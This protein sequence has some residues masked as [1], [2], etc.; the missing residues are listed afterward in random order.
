MAESLLVVLPLFLLGA[1]A[2]PISIEARVK[3]RL[4]PF[5]GVAG[6]AAKNLITG[7]TVLVNADA[8][9]PTAS[10]IKTAVMVEVFHQ[11][12]EGR[13]RRD[14]LV[15]L[16]DEVK[17]GEP[18]VLNRLH[19]GLALSVMDLVALMIT[20]SDNT[21]TN[22]LISLVGTANVDRR[23]AS[24]GLTQTKL[25]R[26]T[27]RDG[28][29][30]VFPEEER[31]FGLGSTTPREMARLM[32]LIVEGKVV[33]REAC[34]EMLE[35]LEEQHD[36]A[37]LPRLLPLEQGL[38]VG[39]KTGEDLEKHPD[40]RGV[41]RYVRADAAIVRGPGVRYV[42]AFFTRQG[43]DTRSSVDND[44]MVTGAAVSRLIYDHFKRP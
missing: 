43:E 16:T 8:R 25:F 37:I 11:I 13:L 18:V 28:R 3:E 20:A 21:A 44:A 22:M 15:T 1:V 31:E 26:P 32:E 38:R 30:D 17:V 35:I 29:A 10:T 9:F 5:R 6:L 41:H 33:S 39:N 24:Y 23:L 36:R 4:R 40:A 14:T 34:D 7:E 19:A 27:F 12:Q 2:Q 42:V